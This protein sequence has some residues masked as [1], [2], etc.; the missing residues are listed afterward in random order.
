M[1]WP[2]VKYPESVGQEGQILESIR[3]AIKQKN[4]ESSRVAAIV[5][6]PTN[7]QSGYVA[8]S[9]FMNE[10]AMIARMSEAALIVDE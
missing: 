1:G 3:D 5:I 10:L 7:A 4:N 6:E 2:S 8:S 9:N